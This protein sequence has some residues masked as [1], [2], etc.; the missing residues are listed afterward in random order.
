MGGIL[1]DK[2]FF[3]TFAQIIDASWRYCEG[4]PLAQDHFSIEEVA[5]AVYEDLMEF[6]RSF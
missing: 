6:I 1:D 3:A 5:Y 4:D 2:D